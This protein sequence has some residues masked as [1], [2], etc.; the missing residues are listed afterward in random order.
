[1]FRIHLLFPI[2]HRVLGRWSVEEILCE[3]VLVMVCVVLSCGAVCVVSVVLM[4]G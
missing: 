4:S 3:G 2:S 1:M